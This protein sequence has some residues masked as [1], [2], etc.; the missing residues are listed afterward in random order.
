MSEA[1]V[2]NF[3]IVASDQGVG[4]TEQGDSNLENAML[5]SYM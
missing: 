4:A 3:S 2:A 5:Y 1:K